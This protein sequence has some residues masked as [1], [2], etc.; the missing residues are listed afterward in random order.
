MI[1][2]NSLEHELAIEQIRVESIAI[3]R[4]IL[5]IIFQHKGL[6]S[7]QVLR[8]QLRVCGHLSN[9]LRTRR[10][11]HLQFL[12][13]GA[14]VYFITKLNKLFFLSL[15]KLILPLL[16]LFLHLKFLLSLLKS[17]LQ[18]LGHRHSLVCRLR[19]LDFQ[20]LGRPV[21]REHLLWLYLCNF[22]SGVS[23][24]FG[25]V[26]LLIHMVFSIANSVVLVVHRLVSV[27]FIHHSVVVLHRFG[28]WL[29]YDLLFLD[30]LV[31]F[32][33]KI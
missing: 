29:L 8:V 20:L 32:R 28:L 2:I 3:L 1:R 18:V 12:L 19:Y 4:P 7:Q 31:R 14:L 5:I 24:T 16:L 9:D 17:F 23:H 22:F 25:R 26:A 13:K 15:L 6:V 27:S 30:H 10:T 21:I 11:N 33:H